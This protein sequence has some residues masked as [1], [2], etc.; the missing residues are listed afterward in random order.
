MLKKFSEQRVNNQ[1]FTKGTPV[2]IVT[3]EGTVIE[4]YHIDSSFLDLVSLDRSP[5]DDT[6]KQGF[7]IDGDLLRP[8][9]CAGKKHFIAACTN[10][11]Q[12]VELAEQRLKTLLQRAQRQPSQE[13]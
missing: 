7:T 8:N 13:N 4:G 9:W 5:L 1:T 6:E 12:A 3:K 2:Y 11:I 10:K